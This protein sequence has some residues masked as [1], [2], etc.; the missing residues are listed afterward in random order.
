MDKAKDKDK[1]IGG[2]IFVD[3]N[4][5]PRYKNHLLELSKAKKLDVL[6]LAYTKGIDTWFE[7]TRIFLDVS[8][9]DGGIESAEIEQLF[10]DIILNN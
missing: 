4:N 6:R 1:D 10:E 8:V 3:F 2:I 9:R 5:L 7:T